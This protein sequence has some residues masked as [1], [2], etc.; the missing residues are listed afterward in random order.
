MRVENKFVMKHWL[1]RVIPFLPVLATVCIVSSE[2]PNGTVT[3]KYFRF[4]GATV[5]VAASVFIYTLFERKKFRFALQDILILLFW[6][7]GLAVTLFHDSS[8]SN[9]R[10]IFLLLAPLY[11][12]FRFVLQD[13]RKGRNFLLFFLLITGLVE[14]FWGLGQ[15]YGFYP[16]FHNLYPVTGSF[17]NPGPYAGYLA[18]IAPIAFYYCINDCRVFQHKWHSRYLSLYLRG[19]LSM[20]TLVCIVLILPSTMSRAAWLAALCGC[21][22]MSGAYYRRKRNHLTFLSHLMSGKRKIIFIITTCILL[23]GAYYLKKDSADG[24]FLIWKVSARIISQHPFGVGAGH[25][26]GSYGEQQAAYFTSGAGSK[27][28]RFVAGSPD[29]GFNE[30]IQTGVEFGIQGLLLFFAI[31]VLAIYTGIKAKR[32]TEVGALGALLVFAGMSYPFS[33][34]PFVIVLVFLL[35]A[36]V[37]ENQSSFSEKPPCRYATVGWFGILLAITV[38]GSYS[39]I[40]NYHAYKKLNTT[41]TLKMG[42]LRS[43]ALSVY[44]EIYN[45]LKHEKRFVFDYASLLKD[46]GQYAES[47]HIL[48]QGLKISSDPMFYNLT[49]I[50]Y[51]L[52]KD[53]TAAEYNFRKAADMVTNRLYPYYLLAKLYHEMDENPDC[54]RF[55][56]AF[57]IDMMPD[58]ENELLNITLYL[59]SNLRSYNALA[60]IIDKIKAIN[61]VFSGTNLMMRFK[62]TT[63]TTAPS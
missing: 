4:Y 63:I 59:L 61:I 10:V 48:Q 56:L 28:E 7:S 25:F 15:L 47:N 36:C 21:I 31:I 29:Y 52:M 49:G 19:G 3:G 54:P 14:A 53:F 16:S 24:R 20:L 33:V 43:E 13:N 30:Y 58:L 12:G 6:T 17:F 50:N 62:I 27:Q 2:L 34:L 44:A 45:E 38:A 9:K 1:L 60:N 35:A 41:F 18:L 39:R 46:D 37:P 55:S 26:A 23:A 8:L 22:C 32:Y 51:Q 11:F 40:A 5:V 42:G 57:D